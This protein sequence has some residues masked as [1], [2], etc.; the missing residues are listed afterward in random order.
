M[1]VDC[2]VILGNGTRRCARF[3]ADMELLDEPVESR[4]EGHKAPSSN[5]A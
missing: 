4:C 5:F 1:V 3:P 2:Q